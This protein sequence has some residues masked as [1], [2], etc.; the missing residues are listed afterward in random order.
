[1][2]PR[3]LD[4]VGVR[5]GALCRAAAELDGGLK[6]MSTKRRPPA[7]LAPP[8]D[9]ASRVLGGMEMWR[10][11]EERIQWKVNRD[12]AGRSFNIVTGTRKKGVML[13]TGP[14]PRPSR[15]EHPSISAL[16]GVLER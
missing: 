8:T 9:T 4:R 16:Q 1:M 7:E 15:G 13:P 11:R 2:T 5:A 3:S 12:S 14:A 10:P 6:T